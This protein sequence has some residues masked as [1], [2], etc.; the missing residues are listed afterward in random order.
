[1][2]M[3]AKTEKDGEGGGSAFSIHNLPLAKSQVFSQFPKT[4]IN[5]TNKQST[6]AVLSSEDQKVIERKRKKI[7]SHQNQKS[8]VS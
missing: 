5:F 2:E 7:I 4:G 6:S 8:A 1:M 3:M